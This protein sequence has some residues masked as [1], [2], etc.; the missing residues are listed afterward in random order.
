MAARAVWLALALSAPVFAQQQPPPRKPD[1]AKI[2]VAIKRGV[3][4]LKT[5]GGKSVRGNQAHELVLLAL[6]HSG[7]RATDP[8]FAPLLQAMLDDTLQMTYRVA[9]QAMV[10]EELDRVKYQKR[11]FQCAQFLVDNQSANGQW[12]Y[13][14]P[15]TYPDPGLAPPPKDVPTVMGTGTIKPG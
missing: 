10:L 6:V 4:W 11:I 12:S 13:G 14:Q 8:A 1:E 3:E 2:D 5:T 9:I 15:T 7:V